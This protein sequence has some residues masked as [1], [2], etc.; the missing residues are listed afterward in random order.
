VYTTGPGGK[1]RGVE[2]THGSLI[3]TADATARAVQLT[4]E[5]RVIG[6]TSLF[7][8]FGLGPGILGSVLSGAAL[9]L[10]EEFEAEEALDLVARHRAT[11]HYGVPSA[12]AAE[13]QAQRESPRDLSSLRAGVVAGAPLREDLFREVEQE[14]CPIL[15]NAYS[16]TEASSTLALASFEDLPEKRRFTVGRPVPG[17]AIR[18]LERD[19][20]D[21][22]SESV[23]ELSVKG[24][25]VMRGYFRQP[26]ETAE[27]FDAQH[28]LR[29]G[30]L[31]MLDEDG[32][33]HL[34][35]SLRDVII[36][37]GF[38]VYPREVEE[39][40]H[41]HPA[42][43]DAAVVGIPDPVL[44][45]AVCAAVV[46]EEGAIVNA[47]EIREWCRGT[48]AASK[49][50]DLVRFFDALPVTGAGKVSRIDLVR[51]ISVEDTLA[52]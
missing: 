43:D 15:L 13:L 47:E 8:V 35:G 27:S 46:L 29:T 38:N 19:G 3:Y 23:G 48:L 26:R 1:P 52:T 11:I 4:E 9:I 22:P 44:G 42:V 50:P 18:I 20:S 32:Y 37:G 28:Y 40:L 10:Q 49:V 2:I 39:R 12:F 51:L 7:H 21:L 25:G 41:A 33:L 34:V 31:A 24:P 16:M 36:R 17:T 6:V 30:D 5:D 45:E 14:L